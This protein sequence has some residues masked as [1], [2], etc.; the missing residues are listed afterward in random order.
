[1]LLIGKLDNRVKL[2]FRYWR[3]SEVVNCSLFTVIG[4]KNLKMSHSIHL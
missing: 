1:M 2:V 4:R 3:S